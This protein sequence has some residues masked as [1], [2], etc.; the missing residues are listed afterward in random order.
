MIW[1]PTHVPILR[2]GLITLR[3]LQEKD[4]ESI[5]QACQDPLI[6]QFTTVPSPYTITHAQ[7]FVHEQEPARFAMKTELIFAIAEGHE[8]DE[9]FCGVISF[10]S[11]N[12]GNHAAEIGYWIAASARGKGI[13]SIAAKMITEY[14]F[15]TM[16]FRRIEALVDVDNLASMALLRSADYELEGVLRQKVTRDNGMQIDMALFS[17]VNM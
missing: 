3:P 14:G 1:W 12:L 8:I 6:P 15:L 9:K 5:Y 4:V 17:K 11:V 13:G 2:H 7:F 10:H 16:G